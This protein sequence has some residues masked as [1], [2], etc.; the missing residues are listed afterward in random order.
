MRHNTQTA[1]AFISRRFFAAVSSAVAAT[2]MLCGVA[3]ADLVT[4]AVASFSS[5]MDML[6]RY[7][8]KT[9]DASG[10]SGP[11]N[12]SDTHNNDSVAMWMAGGVYK[13]D[14]NPFITF[15][16]GVP[17]H[18]QTTRIWQ[19]NEVS[20]TQ[21]SASN[22][23]ISVSA[24]N[25]TFTPFSTNT[26]TQAGGTAFEPAQDIATDATG[27]R[28]VKIQILGTWDGAV[29]WNGGLGPNGTDT[30]Y[31][32][33]FSEVRFEVVGAVVLTPLITTQ[34]HSQTNYVGSTVHFTVAATDNSNPPLS[35]QWRKN[36][37]NLSDTGHITGSTNT[38]LT[39]SNV[40]TNDAGSY[41]V[42]VSN[43]VGPSP[44]DTA[45][46]TVLL[47]PLTTINI[48]LHPG[49]SF[50][51]IA[52]FHYRV[53]YRNALDPSNAWQTLQEIPQLPAS[54]SPYTVYDP[55]PATMPQ[56]L[57]RV[58]YVP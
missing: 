3:R 9:V 25:V 23:V 7:A 13:G 26:L 45:T 21:V 15:D 24:D 53:E 11:G 39:I 27:V 36:G 43:P 12:A 14:H 48:N 49:T 19:Y 5:E 18:L 55:T 4:P 35:Y 41:D 38:T 17:Y 16:L 37:G 54:P 44:S 42:V 22:I 28:Y 20:F 6:G 46:L 50:Q 2:L 47:S 52:G 57:Y 56:R 34:P 33:G 1:P 29:F 58:V 8:T 30:R 40:T 10:M 51:G 32:S 31:L